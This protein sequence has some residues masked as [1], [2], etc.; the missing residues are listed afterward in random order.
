MLVNRLS[1]PNYLME[2]VHDVEFDLAPLHVR[3]VGPAVLLPQRLAPQTLVDVV[4]QLP[5]GGE[6]VLVDLDVELD[7]DVVLRTVGAPP[8]DLLAALRAL[9]G[10]QAPVALAPPQP[11]QHARVAPQLRVAAHLDEGGED[12]GEDGAQSGVVGQ[13][14]RVAQEERLAAAVLA[15]ARR[16]AD[17][18]RD[19]PL[20]VGVARVPAV[21]RVTLVV[22]CLG[23]VDL[24]I[25]RVLPA[26][27]QLL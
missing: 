20:V 26:G 9:T 24:E 5:D 19:Q 12:G 18:P 7:L 14:R 17:V 4:A 3:R 8:P 27:G 13:E 21:Y 23:W 22:G 11:R 16:Q 6:V 10:A 15:A 2:V 25:W 1:N